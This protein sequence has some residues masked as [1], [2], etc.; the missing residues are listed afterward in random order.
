MA[1]LTDDLRLFSVSRVQGRCVVREI[2]GQDVLARRRVPEPGEME[3]L[4][5][6]L[7]DGVSRHACVQRFGLSWG[8]VHKVAHELGLTPAP[9][10][11]KRGVRHYTPSARTP[12]DETRALVL[13]AVEA[14]GGEASVTFLA[15]LVQRSRPFVH[16]LLQMAADEGLV[17]RAHGRVRLLVTGLASKS[18][19][20]VYCLREPRRGLDLEAR[21]QLRR[22]SAPSFAAPYVSGGLLV[23]AGGFYTTRREG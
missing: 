10:K 13:A 8:V 14:L 21:F 3:R 5:A 11:H 12:S 16:D 22:D 6:A 23:V 9:R 1:S 18:P 20:L 2:S 17:D 15:D 19:V 7:K 4:R